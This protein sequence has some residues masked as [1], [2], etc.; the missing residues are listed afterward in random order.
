MY[1]IYKVTTDF[2]FL[3]LLWGQP[4]DAVLKASVDVTVTVAEGRLFPK[5]IVALKK[6]CRCYC[7]QTLVIYNYSAYDSTQ[8]TYVTLLDTHK[9]T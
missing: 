1:N 6:E 2:G 4:S 8:T 3:F 9:S 5:R 7:R